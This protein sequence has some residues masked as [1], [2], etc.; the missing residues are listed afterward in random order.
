MHA[1]RRG[2]AHDGHRA[3]RHRGDRGAGQTQ[4]DLRREVG[5]GIEDHQP[6]DLFR[7]GEREAQGQCAPK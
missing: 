5:K 6:A 4:A 7:L 2:P 1:E 3:P